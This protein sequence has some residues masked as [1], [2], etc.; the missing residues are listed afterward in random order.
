[1]RGQEEEGRGWDPTRDAWIKIFI[2]RNE[3]LGCFGQS[4]LQR[5]KTSN[6]HKYA[7]FL[8]IFFSTFCGKNEIHFFLSK[9]L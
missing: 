6:R 7:T 9:I 4:G 1:M 8:E 3:V 2:K 5:E